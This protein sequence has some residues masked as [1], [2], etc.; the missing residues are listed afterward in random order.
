MLDMLSLN[1]NARLERW[2]MIADELAARFRARAPEHDRAGT[3]PSENFEDIRAAQLHL[4]PVPQ[5][6]GGWGA[7]LPEAVRV[8][9]RLARG[10]GATALVFGMHVQVVGSLA[11]TRPWDNARFADFCRQIVEQGALVNSAATEPQ[12]GSPSR[13]GLPATKARWD[14]SMWRI[15]GRKSWAS[16]A[17][18]LTHFLIPAVL[19]DAPQGTVGVFLVATDRRG[20]QIEETWDP[21]GMR[22]TG[23]HDLVLEDVPID[24]DN[25]VMRR[26]PGVPDP[27]KGS[28]GAWFGLTVGGVYLGVAQAARD[29]ALQFAQERTPTALRGAQIATLEPIQRLVG[30]LESELLTARALL[31]ATADAWAQQPEQR[32]SLAAHIGLSKAIATQHAVAATD[33]ALRV[34]GGQSMARSFPLERLF[35]DVRAGLF[36]PPTEDA[37]YITLGKSLLGV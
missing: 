4:L 36:H 12:L 29:V 25:L 28:T 8:I 5:E 31:Y 3:V 1:A 6:Y 32:T 20:I 30:Q 17:P 35:R 11:E 23:S 13:G 9:E 21:L 2:L 7:T 26:E 18:V 15:T 19:E 14:G 34:V 24:G 16:G 22:S 37:A 33:L 27:G 10:D